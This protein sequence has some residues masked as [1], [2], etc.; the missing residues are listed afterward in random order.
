MKLISLTTM[1]MSAATIAVTATAQIIGHPCA[2]ADSAECGSLADH[3]GGLQF[4]STFK[5]SQ[6]SLGDIFNKA[7][8]RRKALAQSCGMYYKTL[9]ACYP[10]DGFDGRG[11]LPKALLSVREAAPEGG[12]D[13]FA[14]SSVF[15]ECLQENRNVPPRA[16]DGE[17]LR[18]LMD[19]GHDGAADLAQEGKRAN[20]KRKTNDSFIGI[21]SIKIYKELRFE[22]ATTFSQSP[23]DVEHTKTSSAIY[24]LSLG[25]LSL[26]T[27]C[28][29]ANASRES[30]S[31][32]R[33]TLGNWGSYHVS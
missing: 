2:H 21:A 18:D 15:D 17:L 26:R 30:A 29:V 5:T 28:P 8:C 10:L 33:G 13:L 9:P 4:L 14:S 25:S 7:S 3:N 23:K 32:E 12:E 20:N 16:Q 27:S 6:A 1:I 11:R 22:Q 24:T 19:S 31:P